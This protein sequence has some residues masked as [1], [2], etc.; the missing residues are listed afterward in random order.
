MSVREWTKEKLDEVWP[1][2][3]WTWS[4][5]SGRVWALYCDAESGQFVCMTVLGRLCLPTKGI[6]PITALLA[7]IGQHEGRD[8]VETLV[9]CLSRW[10]E[11][12]ER[13]HDERS[14]A[15]GTYCAGQAHAWKQATKILR[16]GTVKS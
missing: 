3:G 15:R 12:A 6:P 10:Q 11:L 8:S 7:V 9:G 2:K 5:V 1:V 13:E 16:R 14:D 4:H